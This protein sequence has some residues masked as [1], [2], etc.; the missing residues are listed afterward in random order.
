MDLERMLDR[1]GI[2]GKA[3]N[4]ATLTDWEE[5]ETIAP[6]KSAIVT[7]GQSSLSSNRPT[8]RG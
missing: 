3:V 5:V 4:A 1:W 8:Q 6:V 7:H 2:R